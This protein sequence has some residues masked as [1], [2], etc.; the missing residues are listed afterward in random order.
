MQ[1][2]FIKNLGTE[3]Y[4]F[5][6][7]EKRGA[8]VS[9]FINLWSAFPRDEKVFHVYG[10]SQKKW[11]YKVQ[12]TLVSRKNCISSTEVISNHSYRPGIFFPSVQKVSLCSLPGQL[13]IT[14]QGKISLK[15]DLRRRKGCRVNSGTYPFSHVIPFPQSGHN[16]VLFS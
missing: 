12:T 10:T 16:L 13:P 6:F 9:V 5:H 2:G 3:L 1:F 4:K 15:S 8:K 11:L 14:P 7:Q